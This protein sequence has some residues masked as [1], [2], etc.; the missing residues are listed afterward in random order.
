MNS[1]GLNQ[2][3]RDNEPPVNGF[4]E[5]NA[6]YT[7]KKLERNELYRNE[8]AIIH[9]IMLKLIPGS[10][11][12]LNL[13]SGNP[14]Q[15][16]DLLS[17]LGGNFFLLNVD[18]SSIIID[19][20]DKL[21]EKAGFTRAGNVY[22]SGE[23]KV[24]NIR[25][26]M[27]KL[28][29][30]PSKAK[31]KNEIKKDYRHILIIAHNS[32]HNIIKCGDEGLESMIEMIRF[33]DFSDMFFATFIDIECLNERISYY[34]RNVKEIERIQAREVFQGSNGLV[35]GIK[36]EYFAGNIPFSSIAR[37]A[38]ILDFLTSNCQHTGFR[39][40][41][42][43]KQFVNK[44]ITASIPR[45]NVDFCGYPGDK[46]QSPVLLPVAGEKIN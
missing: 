6:S 11:F 8:S 26:D 9:E 10:S 1:Y 42:M 29:Q 44:L 32:L 33:F 39:S 28:P 21:C 14:A 38:M 25:S 3:L 13:G 17:S 15:I 40:V 46:P 37:G 31:I 20:A 7:L 16:M 41:L 12:I 34:T 35:Y 2:Y 43:A 22:T 18:I 23:I 24:E 36:T 19:R 45:F 30:M 27:M 4:W 5:K